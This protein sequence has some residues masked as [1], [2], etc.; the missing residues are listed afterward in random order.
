MG[1]HYISEPEGGL[2]R[3]CYAPGMFH[4]LCCCRQGVSSVID[5]HFLASGCS[6][7]CGE[8]TCDVASCVLCPRGVRQAT[9]AQ[10]RVIYPDCWGGR[11]EGNGTQ[12]RGL[13]DG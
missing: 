5:T 12:S 2:S 6:Q 11:P 1:A 9:G 10:R 13:E 8:D 4:G 7:S 3:E